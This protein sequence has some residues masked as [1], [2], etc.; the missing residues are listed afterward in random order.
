MFIF[1]PSYA[2]VHYPSKSN[3]ALLLLHISYIK[4]MIIQMLTH[5]RLATIINLT[6][7]LISSFQHFESKI[8]CIHSSLNI[9][10][11][12]SFTQINIIQMLTLNKTNEYQIKSSI[13]QNQKK[14]LNHSHQFALHNNLPIFTILLC[15][16]NA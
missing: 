1:K 5:I 16:Y 10:I 15:L 13:K 4:L 6:S 12:Y 11:T 3:D 2:R 9:P 14:L 8:N 7:H